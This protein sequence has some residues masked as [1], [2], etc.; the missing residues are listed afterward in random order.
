M[1]GLPEAF[2][3]ETK[4]KIL[5]SAESLYA[6]RAIESVSFREIGLRAGHRNTNAVQ[7][8]FGNRDKLVQSIFAWRVAQMEAPR[9]AVLAE[10]E[11]QGRPLD[12]RFLMRLLCEPILDLTDEEGR[13]SYAGFMSQYLMYGRPAGVMHA[14]DTRP[15]LSENLNFI[16][17]KLFE[18]LQIDPD[19]VSDYRVVIAYLLV[20]NTIVFCDS[21]GLPRRDPDAFRGRFEQALEMASAALLATI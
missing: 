21:E 11:A 16:Q 20:M 1:E 4:I 10:A 12:T 9:R 17:A 13:H 2:S 5:Q 6:R 19:Q 7:Y 15:E 3:D 18:Q 8:H 14:S